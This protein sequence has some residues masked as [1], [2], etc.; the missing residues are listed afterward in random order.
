MSLTW[1][2]DICGKATKLYPETEPVIKKTE[3]GDQ[4]VMR[5]AKV[6]NPHTGKMET[7]EVPKVQ[8][9]QPRTIL[10]QLHVGQDCLKHDFCE[11]CYK[12]EV[13]PSMKEFIKLMEKNR[14]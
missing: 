9:L 14:K 10:V 11:A 4:P 12:K 7:I 13:Q 5:K 3:F 1:N 2:C 6:Q 8:Y